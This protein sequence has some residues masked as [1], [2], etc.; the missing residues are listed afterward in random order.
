MATAQQIRDLIT[1]TTSGTVRLRT[2]REVRDE[3]CRYATR[4]RREGAPWAMISRETGLEVRKLQRWNARAHRAASVPVLRP[5]EVVPKPDVEP[6][7][8]P[9]R[10][11][12]RDL[13]LPAAARSSTMTRVL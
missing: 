5:V 3:V 2:P 11:L 10:R 8:E 12:T 4:R 7:R 13:A 9:T 1:Q 6:A